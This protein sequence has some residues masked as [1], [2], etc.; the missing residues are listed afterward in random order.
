M[1]AKKYIADENL[2]LGSHVR[3]KGLEE[4]SADDQKGK[5]H[6]DEHIK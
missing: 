4:V 6:C 1:T 3:D 5:Q 2:L